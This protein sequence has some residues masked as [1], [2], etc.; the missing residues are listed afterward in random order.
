MRILV[1]TYNLA[2]QANA[3][4]VQTKIEDFCRNMALCDDVFIKKFDKYNDK[5]KDFDVLH[6]FKFTTDSYELVKFA[7]KSEVGVKVVIS[8]VMP[9]LSKLKVKISSL[10]KKFGI[11]TNYSM[12]KEMLMLA[13]AI[14]VET[15]YEQNLI[16]N[17]FGIKK[18]KIHIIPNIVDVT[19][20][21]DKY[22]ETSI[23]KYNLPLK[24]VLQIGRIDENKNQLNVIRALKGKNIPIVFIGGGETA[25][26]AYFEKCKK[27]AD[28][29]CYFL[30]WIP[31]ESAEFATILN[32]ADTIILPSFNE[33]FGIALI[34][35]MLIHKKVA[36][37]K[38]LPIL[39]YDC[40]KD[41]TQFA[42]NDIEDIYNK[43]NMLFNSNDEGSDHNNVFG[44]DAVCARNMSMYYEVLNRRDV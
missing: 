29:N 8:A 34:E 26:S 36:C 33:T 30:G 16:Q 25:E 9:K 37:S 22:D 31:H 41:I 27:E 13:D 40:L 18:D 3:G 4:G 44:I 1:D 23:I 15:D 28:K 11:N 6:I 14:S 24:Y 20:I 7:K 42:P 10:M 5:L 19:N 12:F 35:G 17:T 32:N 39:C 21:K 38:T 2:Y 43:I